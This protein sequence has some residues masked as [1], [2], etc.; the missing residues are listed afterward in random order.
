MANYGNPEES[1]W[2]SSEHLYYLD[3]FQIQALFFAFSFN[4]NKGGEKIPDLESEEGK[5]RYK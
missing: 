2:M 3:Y 4:R 1:F 5:E